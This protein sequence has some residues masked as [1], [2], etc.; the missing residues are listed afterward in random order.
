MKDILDRKVGMVQIG[1]VHES[2][3]KG[4]GKDVIAISYLTEEV[5]SF[6]RVCQCFQVVCSGTR[7]RV[8]SML[9]LL[10]LI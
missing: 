6:I 1:A 7:C 10:K 4:N 2:S 5:K 8:A 9:S 3:C